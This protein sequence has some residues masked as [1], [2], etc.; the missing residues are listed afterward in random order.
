MAE[1][2]EVARA[3]KRRWWR[4][5]QEATEQRFRADD[6]ERQLAAERAEAARRTER[7]W[8]GWIWER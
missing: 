5:V 8:W 1:R 3:G 6:L 2:A 7:R 4:F